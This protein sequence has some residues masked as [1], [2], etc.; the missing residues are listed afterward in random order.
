MPLCNGSKLARD[1][2]AHFD[3]LEELDIWAANPSPKLRGVLEYRTRRPVHTS[4]PGNG[5]K[6]LVGE[7]HLR[8]HGRN[9]ITDIV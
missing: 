4:T 9:K 6:L 5:G 1:D 2:E 7:K 3:S 8:V